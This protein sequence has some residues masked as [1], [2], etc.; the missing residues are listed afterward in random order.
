MKAGGSQEGKNMTADTSEAVPENSDEAGQ[1]DEVREVLDG[2]CGSPKFINSRFLYDERGSQLFDRIT[3]LPEYYPTRTELTILRDNAAAIAEWTGSAPVLIE[4]GAG[5]CEKVQQLLEALR[6]AAYVPQDISVAF[7]HRTARRLESR[8]PWLRVMPV[9]G[10]FSDG[11]VMPDGVPRGRRVLFYPG[12]TIGNFTPEE[13]VR[14][15]RRMR[16]LVGESGGI[17]LG[18]DLQKA[19]EILNAA[20]NDSEGV[21]A[22]FNRN[23]LR[24]LARILD[25]DLVP[26][27]FEHC[28]FYN[29]SEG[30]VE[31]HLLCQR[32]HTVR[33]AGTVLSFEAGDDI[34]T[35]YSC[36]YT[37]EMV[38]DMARQAGLE[39]RRT[40][41]D[42]Q[43]LFSVNYLVPSPS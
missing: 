12:S 38:G 26:E 41:T 22:E 1:S 14:F 37:P 42:D 31:M 36:K 5:S 27:W 19:P 21:T 33:C 39:L 24:H 16:S 30:R 9:T 34:L 43:A 28:A 2:L 23:I 15:L 4:P 32:T 7:L 13:A 8:Y 10:D 11:I 6:P 40:W 18:A 25:A 3:E 20:Y 35:E 17:L 29:R